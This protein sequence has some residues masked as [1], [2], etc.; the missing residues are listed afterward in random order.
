MFD[1]TRMFYDRQTHLSLPLCILRYRV[2][3]GSLYKENRERVQ[4]SIVRSAII[5][6]HL[7]AAIC[8]ALL[9][10]GFRS[11]YLRGGERGWVWRRPHN[12]ISSCNLPHGDQTG[13]TALS[14]IIIAES[15][16]VKDRG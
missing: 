11:M 6:N 3:G 8:H 7:G 15:I 1:T 10:A 4:I 13:L 14:V 12:I 16:M 9:P 5:S 2:T